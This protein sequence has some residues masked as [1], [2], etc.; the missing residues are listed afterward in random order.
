MPA[1]RL[2]NG[3]AMERLLAFYSFGL[4][5]LGVFGAY[6]SRSIFGQRRSQADRAAKPVY[7]RMFDRG[8][9]ES[10]DDARAEQW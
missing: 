10:K 2:I 4:R 8:S 1:N 3:M 5:V 9:K 7:Q 6:E